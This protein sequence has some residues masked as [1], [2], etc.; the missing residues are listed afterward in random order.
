M[1]SGA[2]VAKARILMRGGFSMQEAAMRLNIIPSSELDRALWRYIDQPDEE[3][4]PLDN[5]LPAPMF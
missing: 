2:D 4:Q 3:L 5:R 1:V